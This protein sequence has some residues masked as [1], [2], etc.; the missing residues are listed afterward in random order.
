MFVIRGARTDVSV[1]YHAIDIALS[2]QDILLP[3]SRKSHGFREVDYLLSSLKVPRMYLLQP[4][5]IYIQLS[6]S[7]MTPSRDILLEH[8]ADQAPYLLPFMGHRLPCGISL[9][10]IPFTAFSRNPKQ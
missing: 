5:F 3:L 7:S 9:R 2:M 1:I 8:N 6:L 4:F 10:S